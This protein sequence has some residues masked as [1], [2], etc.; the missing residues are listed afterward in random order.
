MSDET[1]LLEQLMN[2]LAEDQIFRQHARTKVPGRG[3]I[4]KKR[5]VFLDVVFRQQGKGRERAPVARHRL[6]RRAVARL[7]GRG[8]R[9]RRN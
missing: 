3:L 4:K 1:V 5:F 2:K 9:F 8:S 7:P 6:P